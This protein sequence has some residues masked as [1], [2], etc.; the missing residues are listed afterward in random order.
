MAKETV[1]TPEEVCRAV[2][3]DLRT[4]GIT[5]EEVGQTIGKS[6]SIVSNLLSSK[7]RF[8]KSMASLFNRAYGYNIRYLLYGE[9]PM[10]G[11]QVIHDLVGVPSAG[12]A[13]TDA[14][15]FMILSSLVDCAEG[16]IRVIGE[17]NAIHAW[18]ALTHGDFAKYTSAMKL[19]S[20]NHD[21]RKANPILAK[22]VCDHV[23]SMMYVPVTSDVK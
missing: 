23:S 22:F 8:S 11:Q 6:R 10:K 2:A 5:H 1:A 7:K 18:E 17:K 15:D 9:G 3:T 21:N 19:L 16:I 4:Q 14:D 12:P 13:S 20:E